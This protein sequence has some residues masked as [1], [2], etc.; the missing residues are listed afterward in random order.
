[1]NNQPLYNPNFADSF[2]WPM[3]PKNAKP[4]QPT[5]YQLTKEPTPKMWE[6]RGYV[7][8]GPCQ[9]GRYDEA[10]FYHTYRAPY[11]DQPGRYFRVLQGKY[12]KRAKES[13]ERD[14]INAKWGAKE[15][16]EISV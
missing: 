1:M 13:Y 3:T 6:E 12:L 9:L 8:A 15:G 2:V 11:G 5:T 4:G 14:R 10:G 7:M 16:M